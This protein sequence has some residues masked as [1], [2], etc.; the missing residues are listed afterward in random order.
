MPNKQNTPKLPSPVNR[1]GKTNL[2]ERLITIMASLRDPDKG[3]SW[4]LNQTFETIA[5][6]T[7]EEAYEVASAI[8]QKNY[9]NLMEELG[10]LLLQVVYY[11]QIAKENG[12]FT[13]DHVV[14]SLTKKIIERHSDIFSPSQSSNAYDP[15]KAWES[16]KEEERK[17]KG[18][19]EGRTISTL[20]DI[21]THYPALLRAI[22][23]QTR[24]ANAG[25]D[26]KNIDD[27]FEKID[28]EIKELQYEIRKSGNCRSAV[29][30]E[31]GDLIFTCA[32]L[33]RKLDI[34]PELAVHRTNQKFE[35]RFRIVEQ[36]LL[37]E[38]GKTPK[39]AT[40]EEMEDRWQRSKIQDNL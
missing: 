2:I 38:L 24:T 22:K 16:Y 13:F 23:L 9:Q 30:E 10:D 6:Y 19:K 18:K 40:L 5:P 4:D 20:D 21:C 1:T 39:E 37:T 33:A 31:I 29:E 36:L 17:I 26:W 35:N 25:Y 27:V 3:E 8:H 11:S 12:L 32:N 28:E 14:E 34:D 15:T 7:I